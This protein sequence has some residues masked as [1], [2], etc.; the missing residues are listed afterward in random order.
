MN[1]VSRISAIA[2]RC[3]HQDNYLDSIYNGS[4]SCTALSHTIVYHVEIV[5]V[6]S[7]SLYLKRDFAQVL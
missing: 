7:F 5:L 4:L 2:G 1:G 6:P 3:E